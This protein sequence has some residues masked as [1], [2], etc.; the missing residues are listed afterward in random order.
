MTDQ[1]VV[2]D[3]GPVTPKVRRS[4]G[5]SVITNPYRGDQGRYPAAPY[6]TYAETSTRNQNRGVEVW[7]LLLRNLWAFTDLFF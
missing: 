5:A 2:G 3:N 7:T 4:S 6:V 1:V